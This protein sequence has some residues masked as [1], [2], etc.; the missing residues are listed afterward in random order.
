MPK[1][2]SLS[3]SNCILTLSAFVATSSEVRIGLLFT[4]LN[5][6]YVLFS[7]PGQSNNNKKKKKKKK[8]EIKQN[9]FDRKFTVWPPKQNISL[10]VMCKFLR[11]LSISK[12]SL[13][14]R[15]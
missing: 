6:K 13:G 3:F 4:A 11:F 2:A 5:V 8:L 7:F 14:K 15:K 1:P 12:N 10:T 9:Y